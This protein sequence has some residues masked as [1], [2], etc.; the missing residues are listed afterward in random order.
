[1]Q[2]MALFLQAAQQWNKLPSYIQNSTNIK[3]F[4]KTPQASFIHTSIL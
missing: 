4:K 1:M 3:E 2:I